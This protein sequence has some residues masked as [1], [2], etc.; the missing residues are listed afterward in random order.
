MSDHKKRATTAG[1]DGVGGV[2]TTKRLFNMGKTKPK[3]IGE[4]TR[5]CD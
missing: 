3:V 5:L 2:L 4:K 1:F